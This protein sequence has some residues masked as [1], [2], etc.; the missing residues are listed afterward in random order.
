MCPTV[1][2]LREHTSQDLTHNG[3]TCRII[4]RVFKTVHKDKCTLQILELHT[5]ILLIHRHLANQELKTQEFCQKCF[6]AYIHY[7]PLP[8]YH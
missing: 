7:A 6:A 4:I 8:T 2:L 5:G 3:R 1:Q